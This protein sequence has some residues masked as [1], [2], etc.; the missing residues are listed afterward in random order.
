MGVARRQV[1]PVVYGDMY[2]ATSPSYGLR[3]IR[4][5]FSVLTEDSTRSNQSMTSLPIGRFMGG[6]G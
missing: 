4:V 3:G 2:C 1:C 5:K 6:V